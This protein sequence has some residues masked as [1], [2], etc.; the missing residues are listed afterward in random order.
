MAAAAR[1]AVAAR[2][3][4]EAHN[5]TLLLAKNTSD[6]ERREQLL[7]SFRKNEKTK[8]LADMS[9]EGNRLPFVLFAFCPCVWIS[10]YEKNKIFTHA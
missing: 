10:R 6:I 9:M 1:A 7:D 3:R 2:M 5:R 4:K 8:F